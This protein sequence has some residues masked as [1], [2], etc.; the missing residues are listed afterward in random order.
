DSG[1]PPDSKDYT[2]LIIF[3]G[4]V[5]DRTS[6]EKLPQYAHS[7]NLRTVVVNRRGYPGSTPYTESEMEDLN[8]G[9][10]VHLEK[11][12]SLIGSFVERFI[13]ENEKTGAGIPKISGEGKSGGVAIMGWSIGAVSAMSMFADPALI[14]PKSYS[15][16][17]KYVKDLV[18]YDP[19]AHAFGY[20]YLS[21][22]Y[23]PWRDKD[24]TTPD[25]FSSG[26]LS[27]V[28][29]YYQHPN[30]NGPSATLLDNSKSTAQQTSFSSEEL[31]R[32]CHKPSLPQEF[33]I[34][35]PIQSAINSMSK[36]VLLNADLAAS[37]F[38]NVKMTFLMCTRSPWLC[39][40][41]AIETR[42]H[43]VEAYMKLPS[44]QKLR[45]LEFVPVDGANHMV[46]WDD[47]EQF[48]DAVLE[49]IQGDR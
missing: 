10:K 42:R 19:P 3:H 30:P 21:D 41:G 44:H 16:L 35:G 11:L 49:G 28:S 32:F 33:A 24:I 29:S 4:G 5:F 18:F 45:E 46:H 25:Q 43:Y 1:A 17:Q 9:K 31:E 7:F 6:F 14:S 34:F 23:Y 48:L 26:F 38:P 39:P 37:F 22:M 13:E 2:T 40:W 27:W 8:Q 36:E 15:L 12:G 20:P 47:P